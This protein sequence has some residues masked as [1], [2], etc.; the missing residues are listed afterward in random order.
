MERSQ[1]TITFGGITLVAG[2]IGTF[3]GGWLG[4]RFLPRSRNAYL[5][6]SGVA[7]LLAAP[8]TWLSLSHPDRAVFV[9]AIVIAEVLIFMCTGPINSAIISAVSPT[10]RATAVGL[11]VFAMHFFGD[12]PSPPLI[13]Y[14]S[15]ASSLETGFLIVPVAIAAAGVLWLCTA[16]VGREPKSA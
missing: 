3:A 14:I 2:F 9:P 6:V 13:G 5:W 7:T 15:D 4:D 12:I 11:S 10:E 8:V 1:A 16:W